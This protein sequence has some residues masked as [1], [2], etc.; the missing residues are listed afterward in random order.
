MVFFNFDNKFRKVLFSKIEEFSEVLN[1]DKDKDI[2][3]YLN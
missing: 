2:D 3:I 1:E